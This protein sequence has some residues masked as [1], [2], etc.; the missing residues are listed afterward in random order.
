[1]EAIGP[2]SF[3]FALIY[4]GFILGVV[5][6]RLILRRRAATDNQ[7][8]T[9]PE[10]GSV[11]TM[12]LAGIG[13]AGALSLVLYQTVSGPMSSMVRVT[14]K[15]SAKS[16]MNSVSSIVIMDALNQANSGDCDADGNVEP[17]AWRVG[18]YGPTN[19][20]L[21]P[22]TIGAPVTD[23]WA[24]DYGYCVWDVGTQ[25]KVAGCD[26]AAG[27]NAQRLSGSPTPT[28]GNASTQTVIAIISAGPNR[29]FQTTCRDYVDATT[30]V[31]TLGGDDIVQRFTYQ[32]AASATSSLWTLKPSDSTQA[33]INKNLAIGPTATPTVTVNSTTG[34]ISA[35]GITTQGKISS[36]G[37]IQLATD[38]VVTTCLAANQ[39]DMRYNATGKAIEVC[40][41]PTTTWK[42]AGGGLWTDS[43]PGYI[44][45]LD[46][47]GA[48]RVG[49]VAT[50]TAPIA[51][52]TS[53]QWITSGSNIY[54]NTGNVGIGTASPSRL[55]DIT[56]PYAKS[57]TTIRN[58]AFLGKSNEAANHSALR[59]EM[60]GGA[61][62]AS[63]WWGLQTVESGVSVA[64]SLVLQNEGGNVGIGTASPEMNLHVNVGAV[65]GGIAIE[66][67]TEPRLYLASDVS[68]GTE[69]GFLLRHIVSSN[70]FEIGSRTAG[71][72]NSRFLIRGSDGNVG[73]GPTA[74]NHVLH[75]QKSAAGTHVDTRIENTNTSG[76]S[77]LWLGS[78]NDGLLRGGSTAG[79]WTGALAMVTSSAAPLVFATNAAEKMRIL[80]D[81]KV[82]IGTTDP[83][84]HTL[85]VVTQYGSGGTWNASAWGMGLKFGGSGTQYGMQFV[86]A[87]SSGSS[88]V[89]GFMNSSGSM[90]GSVTSTSAATA[91]NTTSDR[92]LKEDIVESSMGLETLMTIAVHDFSFKADAEKT[93]HQ[94]FI[95][96]ELHEVYPD[97]V[98]VGGKDPK[99]QPWAVD[100][101]KL[102]PLLVKSVQELDAKN[103]ELV[104]MNAALEVNS[105]QL[106]S[107]IEKLE[108]ALKKQK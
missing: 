28:A 61:T 46:A 65:D 83:Y 13:M 55:L 45:Y 102:T 40:D 17:R 49:Q 88:L 103:D 6:D 3:F 16:Q 59:L 90:V 2:L 37:A 19:G 33:V 15:T 10:S 1:M 48:M 87:D 82:G 93:K 36:G 64:G 62:Q 85:A 23:P 81:G 75:L 54:Y 104:A 53:S 27:P 26:G 84:V 4:G 99:M 101:G 44:S 92:R 78:G 95:A 29:Q 8:R 67:S 39:G 86:P 12:L 56:I 38:A 32:E 80:G 76:Y 51:G 96:Q 34:L 73:I 11:F 58:V 18:T 91:F 70:T 47:L 77:T 74:P 97:A 9:N 100:Y 5:T 106:E 35:L 72:F 94:G 68:S 107:R 21:I 105:K 30:D 66:G 69:D 31:I 20:G 108:R 50:V 57:D 14:N 25:I 60:Q 89:L 7:R 71:G 22:L 98:T 63:R 41:G 79:S 42:S 43:G 52:A 24:T